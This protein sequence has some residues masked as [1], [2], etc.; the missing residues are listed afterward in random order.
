MRRMKQIKKEKQ[1]VRFD[2][3]INLGHILSLLAFLGSMILVW[4]NFSVGQTINANDIK[5][6][7]QENVDLRNVVAKIQETNSANALTM[8]RITTIISLMREERKSK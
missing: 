2:L 8:E 7:K 4:I 3:S 1:H 6:L 5:T